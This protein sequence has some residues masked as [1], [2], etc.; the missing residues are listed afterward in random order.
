MR[1]EQPDNVI[2]VVHKAVQARREAEARNVAQELIQ[3]YIGPDLRVVSV[4]HFH[5]ALIQALKD[6]RLKGQDDC[7]VLTLS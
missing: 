2:A 7:D 4:Q 3:T 6:A 1:S 5:S